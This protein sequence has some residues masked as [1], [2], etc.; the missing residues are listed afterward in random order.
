MHILAVLCYFKNF[1]ETVHKLLK[2]EV[3]EDGDSDFLGQ[4]IEKSLS[5]LFGEKSELVMGP[6]VLKVVLVALLELL[7]KWPIVV[8]LDQQSEELAKA[9]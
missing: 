2:Y 5:L 3:P 9:L 7:R 8:K 1:P 6:V 4:L